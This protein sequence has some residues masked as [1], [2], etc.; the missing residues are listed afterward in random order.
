MYN[1]GYRYVAYDAANGEYQEFKTIKEAQ[2]WL[3][4]DDYDGIS[5]EAIEGRNYIA[6]IKY[7]SNVIVLDKKEDYHVHT[8]E[9]PEDCNEK[10]WEY[11]NDFDW[12][13]IQE[14][15]EIDWEE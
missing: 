13:G 11:S 10:E 5:N 14:F 6:E 2:D 4:E 1:K 15:Q 3:I 8:D 9:C 12:I 7:K